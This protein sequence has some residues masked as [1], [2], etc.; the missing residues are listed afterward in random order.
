MPPTVIVKSADVL[1]KSQREAAAKRVITQ[2]GD[3]IPDRKLL[4]FFDDEDW[5]D[6]RDR[7]GIANRGFYRQLS[8]GPLMSWPRYLQNHIFVQNLQAPPWRQLAFDHVTYLYGSTCSDEVG[9]TMTFA[10]ELQHFIQ[11]SNGI[12][13]WA[14]NSSAAWLDKTTLA[15]TGLRPCDI[16]HEREARIVSKRTAEQL[17][18]AATCDEIH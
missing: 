3:Q 4:C 18:G 7:F 1:I 10:H 11:R 2:F 8:E 5:K 15:A 17:F 12:H 13:M 9:M 14:A 16:P 6:F